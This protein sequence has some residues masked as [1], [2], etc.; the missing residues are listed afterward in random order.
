MKKLLL[1][2]FFFIFVFSAFSFSNSESGSIF[3]AIPAEPNP[4]MK[5]RLAEEKF[6]NLYNSIDYGQAD[7][8]DYLI[9]RKAYV[10]YLNLM[11]QDK[12]SNKDI[13]TLI[14]F[15]LP[16]VQKRLWIVDL[17]NKKLL[18][19]DLVAHGK[20]SGDNMATKFSNISNSN[21]SSLGFYVTGQKYTGKH[22]LSLRLNG[23]EVGYN[24]KAMERA[25]VMHG[26]NYVNTEIC[27]SIGRLGRS[28][29]CPAVSMAIYKDVINTVAD[30][31]C[32]F[33]YYPDADYQQ[34]SLLLKEVQA[35]EYLLSAD[36]EV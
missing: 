19:H 36:F 26:A 4:E 13:L 28:F 16:S 31:S 8:P 22:G 23:Q 24:D 17:K 18:F 11:F 15:S 25:V 34:K 1:P 35:I 29:G 2:F 32:M 20:N 5:A 7:K 3:L 9:F 10:G 33:I 21:M 6:E 30:G 27:K 14:D 12:L